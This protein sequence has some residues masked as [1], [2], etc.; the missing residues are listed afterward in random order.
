MST[1]DFSSDESDWVFDYVMHLFRSPAWEVPI[2]CF[3]DEN[4]ASFDTGDENK[5]VYTDLHAQFRDVGTPRLI[6]ITSLLMSARS[7]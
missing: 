2:M 1:I 3:I 5:F 4:C 6:P 7:L